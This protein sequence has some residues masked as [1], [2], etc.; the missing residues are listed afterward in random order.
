MYW[1]EVR[2]LLNYLY[3]FQIKYAW[4]EGKINGSEMG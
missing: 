2:T 4:L 1:M 3:R